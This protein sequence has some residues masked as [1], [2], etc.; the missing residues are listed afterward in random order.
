MLRLNGQTMLDASEGQLPRRG[1]QAFRSTPTCLGTLSPTYVM[2]LVL[3]LS[4]PPN[5]TNDPF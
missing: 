5:K 1:H 2:S 3:G 4:Q